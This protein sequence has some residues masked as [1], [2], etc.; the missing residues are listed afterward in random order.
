MRKKRI[1]NNDQL[2]IILSI[3]RKLSFRRK[4]KLFF[5]LITMFLS[6]ISEIFTLSAVYPFLSLLTEKEKFINRISIRT[7]I[8]RFEFINS[9]NI[10]LIV[11][12]VFIFAAF[13][14]ALCVVYIFLQIFRHFN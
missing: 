6:A 1:I 7:I 4:R 9:E 14:S 3:Y 8:Q 11:T 10:F 2:F 13:V 5:L 12:F